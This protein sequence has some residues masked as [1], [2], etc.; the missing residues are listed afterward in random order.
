MFRKIELVFGS[1]NRRVARSASGYS[2]R[3]FTFFGV[4]AS[5]VLLAVAFIMMLGVV[6]G[7][8]ANAKTGGP[9]FQKNFKKKFVPI[10]RDLKSC[11][12]A[13]I[14]RADRQLRRIQRQI[15][16]LRVNVQWNQGVSRWIA[17]YA[18]AVRDRGMGRKAKS[19]R[20]ARKARKLYAMA[21]R[22]GNVLGPGAASSP[23]VTTMFQGIYN[24]I[25]GRYFCG[26][27]Y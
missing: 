7:S 13:K 12:K 1:E 15:P 8:D 26:R 17:V 5:V 2:R 4:M 19:K 16:R 9:A 20:T 10:R 6:S 18:Q 11:S 14:R 27:G 21:Y 23:N 25:D 24:L 22:Q 3:L